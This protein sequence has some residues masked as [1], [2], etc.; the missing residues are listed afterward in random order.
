MLTRTV[1]LSRGLRATPPLTIMKALLPRSPLERC[2]VM[3]SWRS[4][5][6]F[7]MSTQM[8]R[9]SE[10]SQWSEPAGGRKRTPD[11]W[12]GSSKR[13][14]NFFPCQS[15]RAEPWGLIWVSA[16]GSGPAM[17]A[18]RRV[19]EVRRILASMVGMGNR[20]GKY[21]RGAR[22]ERRRSE[23]RGSARHGGEGGRRLLV[24]RRGEVADDD[25]ARGAIEVGEDDE[26]QFV[27]F[28]AHDGG[29]EN[30]VPAVGLFNGEFHGH[31]GPVGGHGEV[32]DAAGGD[33][34]LRGTDAGGERFG[35]ETEHAH[36]A[37]G[38]VGAPAFDREGTERE[39]GVAGVAHDEHEEAFPIG[40]AAE[41]GQRLDGRVGGCTGR[42]LR[43]VVGGGLGQQRRGD[44]ADVVERRGKGVGVERELNGLATVAQGEAG[45]GVFL[46]FAR[47]GEADVI[48]AQR[49]RLDGGG[50][51]GGR[52]GE[53]EQEEKQGG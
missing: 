5:E 32:G 21:V 22:T 15:T 4:R 47:E 34:G 39:A 20:V 52:S 27:L 28:G 51:R 44:G 38:H 41:F 6:R 53:G 33:E 42:G 23:G 46:T 8:A 12:P 24:G 14:W 18:V 50:L 45:A 10:K 11:S 25:D 9:P 29:G 31:V 16:R 13:S 1:R 26:H 30:A 36:G 2:T 19:T 17:A 3:R 43:G 35:Q 37:G 7:L 40:G 48:K 49:T